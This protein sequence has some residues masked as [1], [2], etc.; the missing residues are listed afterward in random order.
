MILLPM[1]LLIV[2]GLFVL[3]AWWFMIHRSAKKVASRVVRKWIETGKIAAGAAKT[4]G[5]DRLLGKWESVPDFRFE[6]EGSPS[7]LRVSVTG[8]G[9]YL[10][11]RGDITDDGNCII[12]YEKGSRSR[13]K[14]LV[15]TMSKKY[16]GILNGNEFPAKVNQFVYPTDVNR[17]GLRYIGAP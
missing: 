16:P 7:L 2:F 1:I 8:T 13:V 4:N 17:T 6:Y 9:R 3:L 5:A 11:F 15:D 14:K 10:G 12:W